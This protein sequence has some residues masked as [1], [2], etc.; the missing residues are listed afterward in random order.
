MRR[1]F[2]RARVGFGQV[3]RAPKVMTP[4]KLLGNGLELTENG[5]GVLFALCWQTV[6]RLDWVFE[7]LQISP[8]KG[9]KV[10]RGGSTSHFKNTHWVRVE[11]CRRIVGITMQV[12]MCISHLGCLVE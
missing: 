8:G 3:W 7:G 9:H 1:E 11:N 6:I 12:S 4:V 5:P 10:L 2:K